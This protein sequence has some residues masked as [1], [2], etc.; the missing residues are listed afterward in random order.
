MAGKGLS[1][2]NMPFSHH[3]H[4]TS[5]TAGSDIH[6]MKER[7][8]HLSEAIAQEA[9]HQIQK[10]GSI[11]DAYLPMMHIVEYLREGRGAYDPE[12]TGIV[13]LLLNLNGERVLRAALS[14]WTSPQ[15]TTS[16]AVE[17]S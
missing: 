12:R 4:K 11:S 13:D 15:T 10:A 5:N 2:F 17:H 16:H 9:V 3:H 7:F 1:W 8:L 14:K 6:S